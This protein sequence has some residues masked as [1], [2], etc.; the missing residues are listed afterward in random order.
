MA[1]LYDHS[2]VTH[3]HD[4]GYDGSGINWQHPSDHIQHHHYDGALNTHVHPITPAGEI[5]THHLDGTVYHP[6]PV[7]GQLGSGPT[8]FH[9]PIYPHVQPN[10]FDGH[11]SLSTLAA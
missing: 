6:H 11:G 10:S 5:N 7:P 3:N 4:G 2:H 8:D 1:H 9:P